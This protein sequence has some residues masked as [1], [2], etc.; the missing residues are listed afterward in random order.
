MMRVVGCIV[1]EAFRE[2]DGFLLWEIWLMA[3]VLMEKSS[4]G[5]SDV[6]YL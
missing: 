2:A 3:D 4:R 5:T 1:W 6:L